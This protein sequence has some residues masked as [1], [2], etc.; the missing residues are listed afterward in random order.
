ML[1]G[2]YFDKVFVLPALSLAKPLLKVAYV[3]VHFFRQRSGFMGS[4]ELHRRFINIK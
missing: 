1:S 4:S 2:V 3:S